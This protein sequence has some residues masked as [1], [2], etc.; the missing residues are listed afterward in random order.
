MILSFIFCFKF[1][2]FRG[3]LILIFL[4][5]CVGIVEI[6]VFIIHHM[7]SGFRR[8]KDANT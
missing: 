5:R 3:N 7:H 2:P 6:E 4:E 1:L 8:A